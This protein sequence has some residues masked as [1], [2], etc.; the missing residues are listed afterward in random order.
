MY[1]N[2]S[3]LYNYYLEIYLDPYMIFSNN[4]K[5]KLGNKYD[6]TN[7]FLEIHSYDEWFQ[8]E[9]SVDLSHMSPL[10]GDE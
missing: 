2:A 8:N 4:K 3:D 5:R 6:P 10:E 7:L 9:E 1:D